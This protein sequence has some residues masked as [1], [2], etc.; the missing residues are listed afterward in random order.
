LLTLWDLRMK[1]NKKTEFI[2]QFVILPTALP[3]LSVIHKAKR[4]ATETWCGEPRAP[5]VIYLQRTWVIQYKK[6]IFQFGS[7][8][9]CLLG[10]L[11]F[12]KQDYN[13]TVPHSCDIPLNDLYQSMFMNS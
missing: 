10:W 11:R 5:L 13:C 4:P 12:I 8:E 9:E 1:Q 2:K 6:K 7:L 3:N